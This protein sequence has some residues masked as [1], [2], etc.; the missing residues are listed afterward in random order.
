[1]RSGSMNGRQ[2]ANAIISHVLERFIPAGVRT[3]DLRKT[4]IGGEGPYDAGRWA[5]AT[6]DPRRAS[7]LL[8]ESPHVE[9]LEQYRALGGSLL[10]GATFQQTRYFRNAA[11]AVRICGSYF[12]HRTPEGIAAQAR[13][14]IRLY[15]RAAGGNTT[16]VDFAYRGRHSPRASLP[17]VR[18]TLTPN[19]FQISDGH[20]RLAVAWML[21]HREVAAAAR[22]P[23]TPTVLQSLVLDCAQTHGRRELYQPV[24]GIEFEDTW[25]VVRRC[26]DRLAMMLGFLDAAGLP[27]A[28]LSVLDLACAYGWF[29]HEF[30]KRGSAALGVD[31]DPSALRIGQIAYGLCPEQ[32]VLNDLHTFLGTCDRTWDVV[33][34]LSVLHHSVLNPKR[35]GPEELLRRVDRVTRSCLFIDTGQAHERW[36]R[37]ALPEWDN[38]FVIDYVRR[39]TSFSRV[40]PLG[41]DADDAGPYRGNY[42]RTLFACLRAP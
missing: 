11:Q 10:K 12:G 30:A 2:G 19:T 27:V 3:V 23:R 8:R 9:L 20:H 42:G 24:P 39:H 36:W 13:S 18:E 4:L 40:I 22:S 6:G 29:V 25:P 21:G 34:L 28:S 35:G 15:D 7:M 17:V 5:E 1:M 33:L 26:H 16:E 38:D 37:K 41:S 14:F 31:T 32:T